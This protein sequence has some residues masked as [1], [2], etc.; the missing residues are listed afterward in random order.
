MG[1]C[2]TRVGESPSVWVRYQNQPESWYMPKVL[3][4][5]SMLGVADV[6][7]SFGLSQSRIFQPDHRVEVILIQRMILHT[8][9]AECIAAFFQFGFS[10][11]A[12]GI[13]R[14]RTT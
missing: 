8:A 1:M 11:W 5:S 9:L 12:N 13:V 6:V 4:I 3:G 7:A 10:P 14:C 2:D